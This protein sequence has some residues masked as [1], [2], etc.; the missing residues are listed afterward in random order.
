M[1]KSGTPTV[2]IADEVRVSGTPVAALRVNLQHDEVRVEVSRIHQADERKDVAPVVLDVENPYIAQRPHVGRDVD[3][4][5][6]DIRDQ[7]VVIDWDTADLLQK[8]AEQVR[9]EGVHDDA[10]P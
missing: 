10:D 7:Q 9:V 5:V 6:R 1:E 4:A 8:L 3:R 2:A